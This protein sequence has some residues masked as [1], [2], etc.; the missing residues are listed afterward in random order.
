MHITIQR[1]LKLTILKIYAD[2]KTIKNF[3]QEEE[4]KNSFTSILV[5]LKYVY[6]SKIFIIINYF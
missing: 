5:T 2:Y 3:Q 4:P 6:L 1:Q